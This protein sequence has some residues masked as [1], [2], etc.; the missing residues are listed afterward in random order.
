MVPAYKTSDGWKAPPGYKGPESE[1]EERREKTAKRIKRQIEQGLE[2]ELTDQQ[3][4]DLVTSR[5][6]ERQSRRDAKMK[7][8]RSQM[9]AKRRQDKKVKMAAEEKA[10]KQ[11]SWGLP[12]PK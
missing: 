12:P 10:K 9:R 1:I 11:K 2:P 8:R 6:K 5:L 3:K 7:A 4:L